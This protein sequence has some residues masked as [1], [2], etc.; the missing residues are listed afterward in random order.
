MID[1]SYGGMDLRAV[2]RRALTRYP[3]L[4]AA[5]HFKPE[6]LLDFYDGLL[7]Q[8]EPVRGVVELGIYRGGSLVLWHE[9]LGAQVVGVDSDPPGL[10]NALIERYVTESTAPIH[11]LWRT[12]QASEDLPGLISEVFGGPVDLI[13]DDA[14]HLYLP[15]LRSFDLLFPLIAPGGTYVIEDWGAAKFPDF[16]RPEGAIDQVL[17]DIVDRIRDRASIESMLVNIQCA[18]IRKAR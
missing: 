10:T 6:V 8:C 15:T 14:S 4:E 13:I 11:P 12:D 17:K 7:P 1:A 2:W 18:V 5:A 9:A 3:Y 16:Q